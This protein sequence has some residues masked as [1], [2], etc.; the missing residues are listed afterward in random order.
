MTINIGDIVK[1]DHPAAHTYLD[2]FYPTPYGIV[3]AVDVEDVGDFEV[4]FLD[5]GETEIIC[6]DGRGDGKPSLIV[7]DPLK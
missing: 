2:G 6:L 7:V 3:T 5:S 1:L 4:Y